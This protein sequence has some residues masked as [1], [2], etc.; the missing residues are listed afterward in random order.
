MLDRART[1]RTITRLADKGLIS[2]RPRPSDRRE[3]HVFLT[4]EGR[5]LYAEVFPRVAGIHRELLAPFSAAQRAQFS[6]LL[7]LLQMQASRLNPGDEPL[8][9]LD[10]APEDS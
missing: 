10:D 6:E 5:R 8:Q 1:S 9:L 7:A 3:V 2:R 4:D